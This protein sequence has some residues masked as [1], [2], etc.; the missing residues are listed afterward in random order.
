VRAEV[1][2]VVSAPSGQAT[3]AER[4]KSAFRSPTSAK[5]PPKFDEFTERARRA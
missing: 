1:L 5:R 3:I 2:E 4:V